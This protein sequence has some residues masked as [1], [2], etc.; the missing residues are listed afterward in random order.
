MQLAIIGT[1][2]C[3]KSDLAIEIAK[4]TGGLILSLDSLSVYKEIDIASAKPTPKQM[5]GVKHFGI[6]V[7]TPSENFNVT[8]FFDL[9][10]EA[11]SEAKAQ[12]A[13]LIIV[14]G[15]SFYLKA[16]LS[17]LSDRPL[18][19]DENQKK[20]TR[21]LLNIKEA[22]EYIVQTDPKF[23][24]KMEKNDK[25]RMEKWYE[26]YYETGEIPSSFLQRTKKEPI[27]TDL[28]VFEIETDKEVLR[29][30]I[31]LRTKKMIEA[32]LVDEVARLE[33]KY[34]REPNCMKSI[35]IKEVIEYFDG[36]YSLSEM[37]E[38]IAQNT[39]KLAKRQR[40]F[41]RTQFLQTIVKKPLEEMGGEILRFVG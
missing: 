22:Y 38:K 19:S 41:N 16:L 25:Y 4:K 27:I 36:L 14:G 32:G 21:T 20:T 34:T 39:A 29:Q 24:Q 35:G 15:T 5:D 37:E 10:K 11:A 1:T 30:R 7:I 3:G 9:Y 31:N 40:T 18:V 6:D 26:I 8:I 13:P 23:A 2:A 12:N 17:G 33:K 28:S